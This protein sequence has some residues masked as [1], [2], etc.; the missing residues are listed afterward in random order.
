MNFMSRKLWIVGGMSLALGACAAKQVAPVK[1]SLGT[2]RAE[3]RDY[4][5]T[6]ANIC[7][8]EPRGLSQELGAVNGLMANFLSSTE[9]ARDVNAVDHAQHLALLKEAG[10][11]LSKV[12]DV[13][14]T[15][16][17]VMQRCGFA[18]SGAF[19]ELTQRGTELLAQSRARLAEATQALALEETQRKWLGESPQREQT[20]R[21]TWCS[22]TPEIGTTDVY[23][24]RQFA[25]GRIEW[26]FCDGHVLQS[27][28]SGGAPTL[29]S[30]EGIT[31]RERRR[32]KPPRYQEAASAYPQEEIDKQPTS[33]GT[34]APALSTD[35]AGN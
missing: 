13:H 2:T 16:L 5:G 31:T 15:N 12:L 29:Q 34:S 35:S 22:K 11:S 26:L 4:A 1:Y 30:P 17:R 25:D 23:Y 32:V 7:N 21:Q 6:K 10:G 28:T 20:A 8:S 33:L 24:A 14:E 9:Q 19:P 18:R 3:Y 27:A